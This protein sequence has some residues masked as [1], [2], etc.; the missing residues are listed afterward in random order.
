MRLVLAGATLAERWAGIIGGFTD[1]LW[2]RY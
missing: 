1:L 2:S